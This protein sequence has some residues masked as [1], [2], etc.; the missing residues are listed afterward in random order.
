MHLAAG[1]T[2]EQIRIDGAEGEPAR[3]GRRARARHMIEQ[4]GDFGRREI[5]VDQQ[6]GAFGD[7]PLM[8]GLQQFGAGVMGAAILP[9]DRIV[10]RLAGLAIPDDRGLALVGNADRRDIAGRN[11]GAR[12]RGA[13]GRD[14]RRPDALRIMLDVAGRGKDLRKFELRESD[15]LQRF[16]EQKRTRRCRALIDGKKM[17]RQRGLQ[18]I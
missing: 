11:A 18:L 15:R 5:R 4:P 7:Q 13:G 14:R 10:D 1:K 3:L 2:P 16:V 12:H 6:S 9:D 17:G 8:S